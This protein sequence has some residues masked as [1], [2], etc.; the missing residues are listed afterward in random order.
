MRTLIVYESMFGNTEHVARAVAAGFES[1]GSET[2]VLDVAAAGPG[3][4]ADC[5]VLVV[6]GPTHGFSMSRRSTRDSAVQQGAAPAHAP[7]G[8]REWLDGLDESGKPHVAAAVFDTRIDKVRHLPGSAARR[9]AKRLRRRGLVMLDHPTSFYVTDLKGPLADGET[10]R[11]HAW[12]RRL[13]EM[14]GAT[15][16]GVTA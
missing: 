7:T 10:E 5:D 4:L 14:A 8:L 15:P 3:V 16:S 6:G 9:A 2:A 12:G 11:A 13:A 1:A